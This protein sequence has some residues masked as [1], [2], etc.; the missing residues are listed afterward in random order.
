VVPFHHTI[1]I[2]NYKDPEI[3]YSAYC[4]YIKIND[5]KLSHN[6]KNYYNSV[7]QMNPKKY[8]IELALEYIKTINTLIEND[9]LKALNLKKSTI[10][11]SAIILDRLKAIGFT[12]IFLIIICYIN[13][14]G[15]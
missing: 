10:E 7:I 6:L 12:T 11:Q 14:I 15:Q 13:I 1:D 5:N 3:D 9:N 4:D 8:S 2:I